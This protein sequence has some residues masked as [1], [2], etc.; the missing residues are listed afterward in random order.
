MATARKA[1][2]VLAG[3]LAVTLGT[4]TTAFAQTSID[5]TVSPVRN[6]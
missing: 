5:P 1:L 2:V 3:A 6:T 4:A